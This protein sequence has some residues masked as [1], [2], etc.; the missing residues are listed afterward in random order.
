M[1][2]PKPAIF[3]V[4]GNG[5]NRSAIGVGRVTLDQSGVVAREWDFLVRQGHPPAL[6]PQSAY[7][8]NPSRVRYWEYEKGDFSIRLD[9]EAGPFEQIL[10]T[11]T[12]RAGADMADRSR[13]DERER[14]ELSGMSSAA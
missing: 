12:L 3:I 5:T 2:L 4:H 7:S 9:T 8:A 11:A 1:P 6:R 13:L 10:L 14:H